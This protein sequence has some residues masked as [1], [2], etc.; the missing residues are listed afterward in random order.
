MDVRIATSICWLKPWR[1]Q[2][3][4]DVNG[5]CYRFVIGLESRKLF[6]LGALAY[7]FYV[8]WGDSVVRPLVSSH[9]KRQ[10]KRPVRTRSTL[11][12]TL[13][14]MDETV[15][16]LST[17]RLER[18]TLELLVFYFLSK[19]DGLSWALVKHSWLS[20][21]LY[22]NGQIYRFFASPE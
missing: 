13:M 3:F 15:A 18:C 21:P 4:A 19:P 11:S 6:F 12:Q 2:P 22:V 1:A 17:T 9:R 14:S 20:Q 5:R 7:A 16:S 10:R 8:H